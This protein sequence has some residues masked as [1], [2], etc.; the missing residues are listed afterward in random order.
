MSRD[1]AGGNWH[2]PD[3]VSVVDDEGALIALVRNP[4]RSEGE[5][6]G[7]A[8]LVVQ[9]P[10]MRRLLDKC[11]DTL[12]GINSFSPSRLMSV[13]Q[14]KELKELLEQLRKNIK[15]LEV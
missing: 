2:T 3:G 5:N 11:L 8:E 12:S 4:D 1:W 9:A 15:A 6:R 14:Q 10:R 13:E 7:N